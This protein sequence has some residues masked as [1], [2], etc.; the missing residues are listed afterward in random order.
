MWVHVA[1]GGAVPSKRGVIPSGLQRGGS[2]WETAVR[3]W[4]PRL[5][6]AGLRGS[7][8]PL[9]P[10]GDH[11]PA[12]GGRASATGPAAAGGGAQGRTPGLRLRLLLGVRPPHPELRGC[13]AC[14]TI[15]R[16]HATVRSRSSLRSRLRGRR[17]QES[18]F[19]THLPL[20]QA[21]GR[22]EVWVSVTSC[23]RGFWSLPGTPSHGRPSTGAGAP[24]PL[25][26]G[27]SPGSPNPLAL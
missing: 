2:G 17:P 10:P 12:S 22:E 27:D 25:A 19:G 9:L 8:R 11:T 24:R 3:W 21:G 4:Q 23:G 14:K 15:C 13:A 1:F 5:P 18:R 26:S 7:G 16:G 20:P 6:A